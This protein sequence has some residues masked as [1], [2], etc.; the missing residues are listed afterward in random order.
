MLG[1]L[2]SF[3]SGVTPCDGSY[4]FVII[5][6]RHFFRSA[7]RFGWTRDDDDYIPVTFFV[8][9]PENIN[10]GDD[11]K[12]RGSFRGRTFSNLWLLLFDGNPSRMER[13][14]VEGRKYSRPS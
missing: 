11:S 7:P 8:F 2:W 6:K 9:S 5:L 4:T 14:I 12:P 10:G 3:G 13:M 1:V